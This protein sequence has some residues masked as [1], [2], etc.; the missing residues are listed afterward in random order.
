MK[1]RDI[2]LLS[3][4]G[5]AHRKLRSWLTI[6]GIVVGVA[7][8]VALVSIGQGLQQS[9]QNQLS[10]LGANLIT[11]SPGFERAGGGFMI[12]GMHAGGTGSANLT[13]NDLRTVRAVPGVLYVG[14]AV[15]GRA[16]A[17]F[18]GGTASVSVQGVD[19]SVWKYMVTTKLE[20]GRYLSSGDSYVA[21]VGNSVAH[22]LFKRDIQLNSLIT[23]GGRSFRVVGIL[24]SSGFGGGGSAIYVPIGN[25]RQVISADLTSNQFS[26]ISVQT[27]QAADVQ[28]VSDRITSNLLLTRRDTAGKQD[29]TVSSSLSLQQQVSSVT[30]TITLFLAG[31][32]AISLLV[33]GIG[34]ANTMFMSV[35]ERTRQIGILKSLGATNGEV[36]KLFLS[37][38]G[39]LGL[40][41]GTI[42][43]GF[44]IVLS[45]LISALGGGGGLFRAPGAGM[46]LQTVVTPEI[47]LIAVGFSVLIGAISGLLPARKAAGLQPVEALRYE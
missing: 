7:A 26:S 39:L 27:E 37:E 11:V 29:F 19:A 34:I 10:G 1:K 6:L 21:V 5:L 18:A 47:L 35:V 4:N 45:V 24:Q 20:S 15:S 9:V 16:D 38:S 46:G 33:G 3:V 32:A 2:L 12:G 22:G 43:A 25:A 13:E 31:I 28:A 41:G 36:M 30:G 40:I 23:I 42:G 44:G 8:V 17:A 14:G